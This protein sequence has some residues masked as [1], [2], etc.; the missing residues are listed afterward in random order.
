[1]KVNKNSWSLWFW[2]ISF[3]DDLKIN[4]KFW[5]WGISYL[6][7]I[8]NLNNCEGIKKIFDDAGGKLGYWISAKKP[9]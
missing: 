2:R 7:A 1:M 9:E 6:E 4:A 5:W 8:V 3:R